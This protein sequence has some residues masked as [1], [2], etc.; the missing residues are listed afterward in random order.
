MAS[1]DVVYEACES[2]AVLE[3]R[4]RVQ[5]TAVMDKISAEMR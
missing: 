3:L 5:V 2:G 4:S 1:R